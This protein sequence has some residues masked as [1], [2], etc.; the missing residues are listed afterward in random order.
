VNKL[1][2]ELSILG[3]DMSNIRNGVARLSRAITSVTNPARFSCGVT[4]EEVK[5][6]GVIVYDDCSVNI[7]DMMNKENGHATAP[8]TGDYVLTFTANMVS[9]DSQAIWCALYKQTPGDEGWKVLGMINNYQ[10]DAG[11]VDDRDSGSITIL[12]SLKKGDQVWVEWRGY[13]KSFLYSN[14]YKLISFSGYMITGEL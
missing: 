10:Q 8:V 2:P 4:G 14:P 11:E 9:S 12:A 6:S 1:R 13:G 7:D 5:V 3:S